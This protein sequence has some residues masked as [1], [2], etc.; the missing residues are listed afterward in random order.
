MHKS[1]KTITL[2]EV[3]YARLKVWKRSHK[4]SFSHVVKRIVPE[5]GTLGALLNFVEAND[6]AH[7]SGNERLDATVDT[8]SAKKAAPWS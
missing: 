5:P 3:A 7:L 1:M 4:E 2:N 8:R 6:A